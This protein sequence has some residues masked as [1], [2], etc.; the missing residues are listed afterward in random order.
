VLRVVFVPLYSHSSTVYVLRL[1]V[2]ESSFSLTGYPIIKFFLIF[3]QSFIPLKLD[4]LLSDEIDRVGRIVDDSCAKQI[5]IFWERK[6][7]FKL[8][9]CFLELFFEDLLSNYLSLCHFLLFSCD[10]SMVDCRDWSQF[11]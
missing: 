1:F 4:N 7:I 3:L 9:S 10:Q 5:V 6:V 8:L 2:S 11:R